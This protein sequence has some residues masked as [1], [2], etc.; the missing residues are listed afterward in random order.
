MNTQT[1]KKLRLTP[2]VR[3]E[4]DKLVRANRSDFEICKLIVERFK[5][6][7]EEAEKLLIKMTLDYMY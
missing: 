2:A 1:P 3:A 6:S 4:I 7:S 5:P